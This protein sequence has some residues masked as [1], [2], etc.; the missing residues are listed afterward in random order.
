MRDQIPALV[1]KC[2]FLSDEAREKILQNYQKI[3]EKGVENLIKVLQKGL[4]RQQEVL[5]N[6]K[7]N[8]A[9]LKIKNH[10]EAMNKIKQDEALSRQQEI[11]ELTEIENEINSLF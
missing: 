4:K 6:Q 2:V 8:E 7:E 10:R 3:S 5:Q 11:A 9:L 1:E